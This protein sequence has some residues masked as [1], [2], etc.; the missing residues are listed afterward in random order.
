L[1]E[2]EK[3][4]IYQEFFVDNPQTDDLVMDKLIKFV[5]NIDNN[6]IEEYPL[7]TIWDEGG[8]EG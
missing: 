7:Y 1:S 2:A 4:Y 5:K 8:D 6:K 3:D